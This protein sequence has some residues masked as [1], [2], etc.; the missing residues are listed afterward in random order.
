[1]AELAIPLVG[2]GAL[3]VMSNQNKKKEKE[4]FTNKNREQLP[5]TAVQNRNYPGTNV[6]D[7]N[8]PIDRSSIN[9]THEYLYPNQ[10]TDKFPTWALS[11]PERQQ[12]GT[13]FTPKVKFDSL[14]G[15]KLNLR[16]DQPNP[17]DFQNKNMVSC[18][19]GN[20]LNNSDF[21]HNNMVPFFGSKVTGPT[22]GKDITNGILDH[23][24]GAG[25]FSADKEERAPLFSPQ[26]NAQ[27]T[28][29]APNNSDF[30]QSRQ[31]PSTKI[32]NV[33]P[34]EQEKVGPGIGLG[35][36][37]DGKAGFNSGL[38]NRECWQPPTVDELR[39][40]T[41]PKLTFGLEGHEGPAL[42]KVT[43]LGTTGTIE[44]NR[45]N[46]DFPL[47]PERWFTTNGQA[48]GQTLIPEEILPENN[49]Q[50]TSQE[51]FGVLGNDGDS[52]ASYLK[53]NFQ[54]ST[55]AELK[56]NHLNPVSAAGEGNPTD[57]DYG[58]KSYIVHSNNRQLNCE[59]ADKG[60][61][62]GINGVFGA[63]VAPI[64]D[65]LRPTRKDNVIGNP[66]EVGNITA[67]VPSLPITNPN[68]IPKTTIKET[69]VGKVGLNYLNV[70][71]TPGPQGSKHTT[72]I[73][74]KDQERN[75]CDSSTLGFVG[76]PANMDGPMS[77]QAWSNQINNNNKT[78]L[79]TPNVGGMSLSVSNQE[80]ERA[81][82][83]T[84]VTNTKS[85]CSEYYLHNP[86]PPFGN[87]VSADSFG[88][89]KMPIEYD[90][91]LHNERM[92]PDILTAFK[93]N[94]YA[95]SLNSY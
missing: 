88:Q 6:Q 67:L 26:T 1:M 60:N 71:T 3:Y 25:T 49:R 87:A 43:N 91:Q 80:I 95:Q 36:T 35:Y 20:M 51:Y 89:I 13:E 76:G 24:Q 86:K 40:K 78:H 63:M 33:L 75:V 84:N 27:W 47:G 32:S 66:N 56:T 85:N 44:K 59:P 2:L 21:T 42:S 19:N 29:G 65:M 52:K 30:I 37:T 93:N 12:T 58:N 5:N 28:Y 81:R 23:K 94:P 61:V 31:L 72:G 48:L 53:G 92:N 54:A 73:Q 10:T 83:E 11:N 16:E 9:Y 45:P 14:S 50:T 69:T 79:N 38:L 74:I 17:I 68:N 41:N 70:G 18:L 4:N 82:C 34:W 77:T 22:A 57:G 90:Q 46:T 7:D 62:G 39:V 8:A 64:I 15:N 55:R